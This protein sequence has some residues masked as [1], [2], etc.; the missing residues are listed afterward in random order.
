M[1]LSEAE[2]RT[3]RQELAAHARTVR[4]Q[5][6]AERRSASQATATATA[7]AEQERIEIRP[8]PG[9]QE[10]ALACPADILIYGGAAGGGK[11]WSILLEPLR[12]Y[13]N[14]DFGCVVFRRI[15]PNIT[16]EG[17]L[18]DESKKLY[19]LVGGRPDNGDLYWTFPSGARVRFGHLQH[20][21]DV[22]SWKG[23]Q[24]PLIEFDQLEEFTE[25]QF[26]YML[27]RNRSMCGVLPYIRATVNPVPPDDLIGGWL[28]KLIGWWIGEDGLPI[29]ER[30]GVLRY[31]IRLHDELRWFDT[32]EEAIFAAMAAGFPEDKA[33]LLPKSL[34]FIGARLEDN[35]KLMEADPGYYANLMALPRVERERLHGGNWFAKPTAGKVFN[36]ADFHLIDAIPNDVTRW[37]RYW[38]KAGTDEKKP[39][40]TINSE[41][42]RTASVKMGWSPGL[43]KYVIAHAIAGRWSAFQRERVIKQVADLDGIGVEVWTEQEPGSGGKE[44][45]QATIIMLAGYAIRA[46]RPM[47]NKYARALPYAAQVEAGNVAVLRASWTEAYLSELHAFDPDDD[48]VLKDQTDAS[49]GA[50][51]K[52]ALHIPLALINTEPTEAERQAILDEQNKAFHQQLL[53]DRLYWPGD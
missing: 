4:L 1:A 23:A 39:D 32:K 2:R 28:H 43:K 40:G 15:Y 3:K 46:D 13:Q 24:I 7:T 45:A 9:P 31:F 17:G 19:P 14:K 41:S 47:K 8:Q 16:N 51:N 22:L 49:S 44:S 30:D 35:K 6:L 21:D 36:R 10:R 42:A 26:W 27:S 38:D 52:L 11:S 12:H 25:T 50:F 20:E 34:T 37:V 53:Q 33:K 29:Q 5:R 48:A 18:W